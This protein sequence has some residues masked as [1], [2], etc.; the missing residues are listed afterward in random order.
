MK[1]AMCSQEKSDEELQLSHDVPKYMGGTD[2]DGRHYLCTRCHDFYEHLTFSVFAQKVPEEFK[3]KCLEGVKKWSS[4]Y[5]KTFLKEETHET[6]AN[7]I[8]H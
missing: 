6:A 7:T 1:C 4:N 3:K 2:K 5:F 8:Q